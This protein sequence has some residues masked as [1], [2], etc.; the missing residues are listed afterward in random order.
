VSEVKEALGLIRTFLENQIDSVVEKNRIEEMRQR[1]EQAR[2]SELKREIQNIQN[3]LP[4]S[5]KKNQ[6]FD[7]PLA[8]EATDMANTLKS[9]KS[10]VQTQRKD[11]APSDLSSS[12]LA[13]AISPGAAGVRFFF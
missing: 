10:V 3:L 9:I 13:R 5:I 7:S 1:Q 12:G 8:D 11:S 6:S 2:V 4:L